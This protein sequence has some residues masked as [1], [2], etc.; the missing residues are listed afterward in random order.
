[1]ADTVQAVKQFRLRLKNAGFQQLAS[2][3]MLRGNSRI[4]VMVTMRDVTVLQT[5]GGTNRHRECIGLDHLAELDRIADQVV[6]GWW[7]Q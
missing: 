5:I 4:G 1:M 3:D 7:P 2:G 6:A